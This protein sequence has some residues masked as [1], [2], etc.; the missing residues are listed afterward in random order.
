MKRKRILLST[1]MKETIPS[2]L[3]QPEGSSKVALFVFAHPDD[4]SF[5][6]AGLIVR[7]RKDGW[8]IV[9]ICATRGEEGQTG[10]LPERSRKTLGVIRERELR[11]AAAILGIDHCIFFPYKDKS[12]HEVDQKKLTQSVLQVMQEESPSLVVTFDEY[13][14]YGHT[15]HQVIHRVTTDAFRLYSQERENLSLLYV[16][17]PDVIARKMG[18]TFRGHDLHTMYI[19]NISSYWSKKYRALC[20][21]RTQR[22]DLERYMGYNIQELLLYEFYRPAKK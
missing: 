8:K 6:S 1:R 16:T 2:D 4:E 7:L 11:R 18:G 14:L 22:K 10:D 17:I 15:D 20:C 9:V 13:G 12:L 3:F 5:T 21:H 19:V